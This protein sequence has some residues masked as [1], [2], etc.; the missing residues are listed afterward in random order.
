MRNIISAAL[1][2]LLGL[3]DTVPLP[4]AIA[5]GTHTGA[6]T[7]LCDAEL[8]AANLL[9]KQGSDGD[10]VAVTAA[11]TDVPLGHNRAATD[12][13]EDPVGVLLIGKGGTK[14]GVASGA[15]AA[16]DRLTPAANGKVA[17]YVSGAAVKI[18]RALTDAAD[19]EPVEYLDCEPV[20]IA[21]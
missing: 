3:G 18:G 17:A 19:G 15:V 7:R 1:E 21:S 14:L 4:N 11:V 12:A 16:G 10:H 2:R 20:A 5:D 13:A 6:I 9:L 8:T